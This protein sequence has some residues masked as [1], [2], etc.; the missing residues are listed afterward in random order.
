MVYLSLNEDVLDFRGIE[1]ELKGASKNS[2]FVEGHK[3]AYGKG[4]TF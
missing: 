3:Q 2:F 1:I 4:E